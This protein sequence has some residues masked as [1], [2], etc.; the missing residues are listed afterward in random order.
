[1]TYPRE[2]D[3]SAKFYSI[4]NDVNDPCPSSN[5]SAQCSSMSSNEMNSVRQAIHASNRIHSMNS[6]SVRSAKINKA[7]CQLKQRRKINGENEN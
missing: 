7:E 6:L 1:M 3:T 4:A 5:D 2:F